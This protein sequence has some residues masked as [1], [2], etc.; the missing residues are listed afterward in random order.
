MNKVSKCGLSEMFYS[1]NTYS[2]GTYSV[3]YFLV[4][5]FALLE[6]FIFLLRQ[7]ANNEVQEK[8]W[9]CENF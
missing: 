2:D 5:V 7:N 9:N 3:A 4:A 1:Q 8:L 6:F